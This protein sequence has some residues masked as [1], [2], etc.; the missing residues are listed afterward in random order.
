MGY[1]TERVHNR[2]VHRGQW[3]TTQYHKLLV[4]HNASTR[5]RE[6][7]DRQITDSRNA[8]L[9]HE[10]RGNAHHTTHGGNLYTWMIP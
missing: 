6:D 7:K 5:M 10:P 9:E 3:Q 2:N 1:Q 8:L 4:Q